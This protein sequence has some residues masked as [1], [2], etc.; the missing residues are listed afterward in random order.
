MTKN[1][2]RAARRVAAIVADFGGVVSLLAVVAL[3]WS[4]ITALLLLGVALLIA[5]WVIDR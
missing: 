1:R 3:G 4:G 2:L 5:G